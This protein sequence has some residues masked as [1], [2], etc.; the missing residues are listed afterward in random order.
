M[1]KDEIGSILQ[2]AKGHE[3]EWIE[4]KNARAEYFRK[5]VSSGNYSD[6]ILMISCIYLKKKELES[7]GRKLWFSD[8]GVL[9]STEKLIEE[10]FSFSLQLFGE[11]I[12]SYI[13]GALGLKFM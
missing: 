7:I 10:E 5:I 6:M 13:R 9:N 12:S 3:M 11:Q 2:R 1:T 4:N 8:E